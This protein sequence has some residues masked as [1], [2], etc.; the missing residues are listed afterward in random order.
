VPNRVVSQRRFSSPTYEEIDYGEPIHKR[1]ASRVALN[2]TVATVAPR[3]ALVWYSGEAKMTGRGAVMA[4][5]PAG[6]SYW[7]WY[8]ALETGES[9]T[10]TETLDIKRDA[11]TSL[12]EQKIG[13]SK[14]I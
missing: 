11:L 8:A 12:M 3:S 7:L 9:W 14:S 10:V 1:M 2:R 4:Y 6:D 13:C 5:V